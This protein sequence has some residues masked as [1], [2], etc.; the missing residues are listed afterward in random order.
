MRP[1]TVMV[2]VLVLV[3]VRVLVRVQQGENNC[4]ACNA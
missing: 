1:R 4:G 2:L 3:L